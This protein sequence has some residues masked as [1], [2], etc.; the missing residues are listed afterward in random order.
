MELMDAIRARRSFRAYKTDPVSR[1][2]IERLL[3]AAVLAPSGMNQQPWAFGVVTD[4]TLLK[5]YSDSVKKLLLGKMKEWPWLERYRDLF[6][7]PDYSV[8][9]NAPALVVVY[10]LTESPIARTDCTLAAE[11]LMLAAADAGL[12]T[13]WIGFATELLDSQEVKVSLGVPAEYSAIAPIIVGIPDGPPPDR[14][15]EAAR[16]LFWK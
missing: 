6:A 8:F 4:R 13:C 15:R 5:S 12:G 11:N 14:E 10:G 1:E 7:N 9:Y 3:E 16:V 2:T